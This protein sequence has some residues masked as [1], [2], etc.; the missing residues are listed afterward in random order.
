MNNKI[1]W[2]LIAILLV[3]IIVLTWMLVATPAPAQ[4]PITATSTPMTQ[5]PPATTSDQPLHTRVVVSAPL[6]GA[7]VLG[8][9]FTVSGEAPGTWYNEAVFPIQVRDAQGN[10]IGHGQGQAQSDWMTT[11]QVPFSGLVTL[12][13]VYHG[14]ATLILL[15]DN[16][17]GL[18]QN[19]DSLEVGIVIQ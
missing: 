5:T 16:E 9:T 4:L 11:A 2:V 13:T 18:P 10:V 12:D 15:K 7:T 1:W 3:I 14:P 8:K 17:S 19:D 6:S